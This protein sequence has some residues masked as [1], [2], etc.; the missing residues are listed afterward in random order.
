[1]HCRYILL[2]VLLILLH[3]CSIFVHKERCCTVSSLYR[4][5][6]DSYQAYLYQNKPWVQLV[7]FECF[8][9]GQ[10]QQDAAAVTGDPRA[11][12][13]GRGTPLPEALQRQRADSDAA[14]GD[15]AREEEITAVRTTP[16]LPYLCAIQA[17]TVHR[18]LEISYLLT[19]MP[20]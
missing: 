18:L 19:L 17:Y 10:I 9:T 3:H 12:V 1:M 13:E 8:V 11:G 5:W 14:D 16:L 6:T 15:V 4:E 7:T 2:L 20:S